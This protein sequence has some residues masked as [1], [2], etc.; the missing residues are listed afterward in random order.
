MENKYKYAYLLIDEDDLTNRELEEDELL[1]EKGMDDKDEEEDEEIKE[2]PVP[3]DI[4][5]I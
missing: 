2:V 5:A 3:D 1:E 4:L